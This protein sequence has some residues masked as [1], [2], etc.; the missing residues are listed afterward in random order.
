[1]L[2][3]LRERRVTHIYHFTD[4]CNVTSIA[5]HGILSLATLRQ[6]RLDGITFGGNNQSHE[7]DITKG[8]DRYVHLCFT[9]DHPMAYIARRQQRIRDCFWLQIDIA[10]LETCEAL[11]TTDV[12]NK[13]GVPL[14]ANNQ[15][16]TDIDLTGIYEYLDFDIA[17]NKRRKQQARKS[18]I[19]IPDCVQAQYILNLPR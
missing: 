1:M 15:A 2:R 5:T 12:A 14:L 17:G 8:L 16:R 11:F 13:T 4:S 6:R 9:T 10:I 18:E 7:L 19:L 3:L